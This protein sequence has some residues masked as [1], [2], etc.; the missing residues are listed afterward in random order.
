[1]FKLNKKLNFITLP[2]KSASSTGCVKSQGSVRFISKDI[3][4]V[5]MNV[6]CLLCM[7]CQLYILSEH[8]I[9]ISDGMLEI[10][11]PDTHSSKTKLLEKI[12]RRHSCSGTYLFM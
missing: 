3:L 2:S 11:T 5:H 6:W 10:Q 8:E 9:S 12:A 7:F 1:M 4:L